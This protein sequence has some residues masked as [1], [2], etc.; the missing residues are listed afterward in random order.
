[1]SKRFSLSNGRWF[2]AI[3]LAAFAYCLYA[4][5]PDGES[6]DFCFIFFSG[7]LGMMIWI[8]CLWCAY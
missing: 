2:M 7:T 6:L 8:R 1:M 3:Y 5:W 4:A